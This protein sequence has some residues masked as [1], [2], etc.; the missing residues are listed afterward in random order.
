MFDLHFELPFL[1][2][3]QRPDVP[4]NC[5]FLYAK[6]SELFRDEAAEALLE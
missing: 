1:L 3:S 4:R 5:D 6:V 2:R